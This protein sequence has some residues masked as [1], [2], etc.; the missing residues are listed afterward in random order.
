MVSLSSFEC[1]LT[2]LLPQASQSAYEPSASFSGS[3]LQASGSEVVALNIE[4]M[5]GIPDLD[6]SV[7]FEYSVQYAGDIPDEM[8]D[9]Q[10]AEDFQAQNGSVIAQSAEL[11]YSTFV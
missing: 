8:L 1:I 10:I 4:E 9:S 6:E 2:L 11:Q 7:S 3:G 5:E